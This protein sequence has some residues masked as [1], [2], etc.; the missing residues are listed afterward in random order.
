MATTFSYPNEGLNARP[1]VVLFC[2]VLSFTTLSFLSIEIYWL[3]T[4]VKTGHHRPRLLFF[5]SCTTSQKRRAKAI[6]I[7]VNLLCSVTLACHKERERERESLV[8]SFSL[9]FISLSLSLSLL[10]FGAHYSR[11]IIIVIIISWGRNRRVK[12]SGVVCILRVPKN[13]PLP[14]SFAFFHVPTPPMM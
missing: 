13:I 7:S 8:F 4:A 12:V 9:S 6:I 5:A 3:K 1:F 11:S 14:L 10:L 2:L